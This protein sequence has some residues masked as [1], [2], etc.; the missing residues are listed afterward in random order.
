MD[1]GDAA[2]E[3]DTP[4]IVP[5]I[6]PDNDDNANQRTSVFFVQ[7]TAREQELP[8]KATLHLRPDGNAFIANF[9]QS[10]NL[11]SIFGPVRMGKSTL[12]NLLANV[13]ELFPSSPTFT[14]H[15]KGINVATLTMTVPEF[16]QLNNAATDVP[17]PTDDITVGFV[18]SEGQGDKGDQHDIDLFS[19]L[20]VVSKV[21]IY[22]YASQVHRNKILEH[23]GVM[24]QAALKIKPNLEDPDTGGKVF[25]KLAIVISQ[26][27]KNNFPEE[28][29]YNYILK[30]ERPTDADARNR[31]R[32]REQLF[33][34]FKEIKLYVLPNGLKP[35]TPPG[36]PLTADDFT[37]DYLVPFRKMRRDFTTTLLESRTFEVKHLTGWWIADM[38]QELVNSINLGE[39]INLVSIF[40]SAQ[41]A[42]IVR[43][44]QVFVSAVQLFFRTIRDSDDAIA[45]TTLTS[46][47]GDSIREQTRIFR[48]STADVSAEL[49]QSALNEIQNEINN[50]FHNYIAKL[51]F[52]RIEA[53]AR[54]LMSTLQDNLETTIFEKY[55]LATIRLREADL[56]IDVNDLHETAARSYRTQVSALDLL[57]FKP[58]DLIPLSNLKTRLLDTRKEANRSN[59]ARWTNSQ[60]D[61]IV[62]V[63]NREIEHVS[64]SMPVAY[65]NK[66]FN[67]ARNNAF[68]L[69]DQLFVQ[70]T[71]DNKE[72][73]VQGVRNT[74]EDNI[75]NYIII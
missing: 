70:Y 68:N 40:E 37:E 22:N 1:W 48:S 20:L 65:A 67:N 29:V 2:E 63:L 58:D 43:A 11:I 46:Q 55:P 52:N 51:N 34:T 69:T 50:E 33:K 14:P 72:Q 53:F 44:K 18:D 21:V 39:G 9:P 26:V 54:T 45:T 74:V 75:N 12:M 5:P 62:L 71:E 3:P 42:V 24:T 27:D 41:R 28:A 23:L 73:V 35:G 16:G 25:D 57:A 36:K 66:I 17:N 56:V 7:H 32:I 10:L 8:E 15:T 13:L 31:N 30:I 60:R 6:V 19:P 49:V 59:W 64:V 61:H 47:Y 4:P 38:M